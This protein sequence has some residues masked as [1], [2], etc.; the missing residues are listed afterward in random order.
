MSARAS[1]EM[2]D[3]VKNQIECFLEGFYEYIPLQALGLFDEKDIQLILDLELI[4]VAQWKAC[5]R[6]YNFKVN[7]DTLTLHMMKLFL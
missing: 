5:S 4:N 2:V 1:W 3:S 6:S 7:Q